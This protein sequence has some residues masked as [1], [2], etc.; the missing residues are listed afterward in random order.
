[1][2]DK[3]LACTAIFPTRNFADVRCRQNSAGQK[4]VLA[5]PWGAPRCGQRLSLPSLLAVMA[6]L[7]CRQSPSPL[8]PY[9]C[10]SSAEC[11]NPQRNVCG[12]RLSTLPFRSRRCRPHTSTL[13]IAARACPLQP[14]GV[15]APCGR[16]RPSTLS[17]LAR[18]A[19]NFRRSDVASSRAQSA[20]GT[21]RNARG[22]VWGGAVYLR[23]GPL[24]GIFL[25]V[26][27]CRIIQIRWG[28]FVLV[29]QICIARIGQ[30]QCGARYQIGVP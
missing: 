5:G 3:T 13:L 10:P 18:R 14:S 9:R 27:V 28:T 29:D 17:T 22:I 19:P 20:R 4:N 11:G 7:P 16:A 30:R 12:R 2:P 6:P 26:I 1:M 24:R 15:R 23:C 25:F 8:Q 21:M